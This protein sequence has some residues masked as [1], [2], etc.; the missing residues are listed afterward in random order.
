M[1][2]KKTDYRSDDDDNGE[3]IPYVDNLNDVRPTTGDE[4]R[5]DPLK[6]DWRPEFSFDSIGKT[7]VYFDNLEQ[8]LIEHIKD[9]KFNAV[10]GCMAWL[11]NFNVLDALE[12]KKHVAILVNKE[13]FLRPD[14]EN[15]VKDP[16]G[17]K[18]ILANKY[19]SLHGGISRG[20]VGG[21]VSNAPKYFAYQKI[22]D[23]VACVG[24]KPPDWKEKGGPPTYPRMHHK[25]FVFGNI[26]YTDILSD[27]N[28]KTFPDTCGDFEPVAVW[29]GSF[30][31][32]KNS[33]NSLENAVYIED[34]KI[35][36]VYQEEFANIAVYEE[37]LNWKSDY[38]YMS[39]R[40]GDT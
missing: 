7:H 23:P 12:K 10:I 31:A 18:A 2:R 9:K 25:F 13:D 27:G 14:E 17:F 16:Q 24:V 21:A 34:P 1:K 33:G 36:K 15:D 39:E 40:L 29:T 3:R 35:A 19:A 28:G 11:T 30:N 37:R 5:N 4:T 6:I 20:N 22:L 26:V 32:S 38:L 8:K